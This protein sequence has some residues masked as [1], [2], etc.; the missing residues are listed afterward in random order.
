MTDVETTT[1]AVAASDAA[2]VATANKVVDLIETKGLTFGEALDAVLEG[3]V[4]V[5][6]G[7]PEAVKPMPITEAQKTAL[8]KIPDIYGRVA[9]ASS[10]ALN[11]DEARDIVEER[12]TIDV[13]LTLL[14]AR[15]DESI[16][17]TIA[18]HL[19]RLAEKDGADEHTEKDRNGHYALKQDVPVEGTEAKFQRSVTDPKAVVS[20]KMLLD[21]YAAGILTRSEYLA[22]TS[23]PVVARQFDEAKARR[24]IKKDPGLLSKIAQATT[25]DPKS[26]T[27]KVQPNRG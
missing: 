26:T 15:K 16:R 20:S 14:K 9:P 7:R 23:V 22:V 1:V 24:A 19:D 12:A 21:L 13:V 18:N 3:E 17:E 11:K 10:R 6:A 27:I 8:A 2:L 25:R 5:V 4:K